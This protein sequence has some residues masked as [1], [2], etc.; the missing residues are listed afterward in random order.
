MRP[1]VRVIVAALALSVIAPAAI[2]QK[3]VFKII[4]DDSVCAEPYTGRVYV[5]FSRPDPRRPGEPRMRMGSWFSPPPLLALDVVDVPVGGSVLIG[6]SALSHPIPLDEIE[7]GKW[8][9]QGV[10]RMNLDSPNPG[11]GA[12]DLYSNTVTVDLSE[13][14]DGPIELV[15][16][17]T[18]EPRKFPE[19]R[20]VK[21]FEIKQQAAQQVSR[22]PRLDA[23]RRHPPRWVG[24]EPDQTL[25]HRLSQH[26]LWRQSLR[27]A[28]AGRSTRPGKRC[29]QVHPTSSSTRPAT[30]GIASSRTRPTT[31]PGAP[32]WSP[33]SSPRS[34]RNT[35]AR[36]T[37]TTASS[38][39]A[40]AA[41]G[42]ASGSRSC[43]P[44][45]SAPAFLTCP[46]PSISATSSASTFIR[47]A[48]TCSSMKTESAARSPARAETS[49][50]GTTTSSGE[51]PS[52]GPAG[53]SV[54]SKPASA[55]AGDDGEPM[56]VFNRETGAVNAKVAKAWEAYDIRLILERDWEQLEPSLAGKIHV[57]AGEVDTFYLEG[58]A[59][60]LMESV[61]GLAADAEV[62]IIGGMAHQGYEPG[63][64][65][66]YETLLKRW[67]TRGLNNE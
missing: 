17:N 41:G 38:P 47:P 26:G 55:R 67:K 39:E 58:A 11:R 7:P 43:T 15:L 40:P 28:K 46:T 30:A 63:S 56:P 61:D 59:R 24:R 42:P 5:A 19:S 36:S 12:G 50:S 57:Y 32:R 44:T 31:G 4:F 64:V 8:E 22:P 49:R 66:M 10:V 37:P 52:S 16:T 21:H 18:V 2:A 27:R 13:K 45:T 53:R 25:P 3:A 29:A 14:R 34:R 6:K 20:E 62:R 51:K 65:K 60:L 33:N 54:H 1:S 9:I 23:R 48:R 35:A